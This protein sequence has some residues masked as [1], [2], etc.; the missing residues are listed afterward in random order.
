MARVLAFLAAVIA[1]SPVAFAVVDPTETGVGAPGYVAPRVP[2][3]TELFLHAVASH[4]EVYV[5]QQFTVT[6][7]LF[8]RLDINRFDPRPPR[9]DNL[10]TEEL[11]KP[12]VFQYH[13]V[14]I[15]NEVFDVAVAS[16]RAVFAAAAGEITIAPYQARIRF[17]ALRAP[18][19]LSSNPLVVI[20]K[21]LPQPQPRGFDP[22]HVGQF[23][24]VASLDRNRITASEAVILT[25]VVR[26]VGAIRRTS[27]PQI[28]TPAFR[29]RAPRDYEETV[30]IDGGIV[31]GERIYRYWATPQRGGTIEIPPIELSYFD[32][33][34]GRYEVARTR[35]LSVAVSGEP[36]KLFAS[37]G[38][39][40]VVSQLR[41]ID[42]SPT[43]GNAAVATDRNT[44][45]FRIALLVPIIGFLGAVA[46][47]WVFRRRLK[48]ERS[49][50]APSRRRRLRTAT[51][52]MRE[53]NRTQFY[54]ELR[55]L[56][57]EALERVVGRPVRALAVDDLKAC[58]QAS[59]VSER[60]VE[61]ATQLMRE[62]DQ[63]S[64]AP[65]EASGRPMKQVLAAFRSFL[66]GIAPARERS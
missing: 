10:W 39:K 6:W 16:K 18:R 12:S 9:F 50:L 20:V 17:S 42:T 26:G 28:A 15:D 29:F 43:I 4:K 44:P 45:W 56:L 2:R 22:S 30:R 60:S 36:T 64:F 13:S 33:E 35:P 7:L 52:F 62:F 48:R 31:S 38:D 65:G 1:A 27:P 3:G 23:S 21:P 32:P 34:H 40:D 57:F 63:E 24:I 58:L 66:D 41:P 25:L 54:A 5:G 47:T 51:A 11:Y 37:N 53:G 61:Q 8:S 14:V 19:M 46:F 49:P 55:R 59:G